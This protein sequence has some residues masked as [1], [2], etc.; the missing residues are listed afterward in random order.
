MNAGN[1]GFRVLRVKIGDPVSL[2]V[3]AMIVDITKLRMIK[4]EFKDDFSTVN[5]TVPMELNAIHDSVLAYIL[6]GMQNE[7]E[8]KENLMVGMALKQMILGGYDV[9]PHFLPVG[10]DLVFS[11]AFPSDDEWLI[12]IAYPKNYRAM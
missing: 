2:N 9:E 3:P 6:P 8:V 12:T 5:A 1:L 7:I 4:G 10:F 11:G